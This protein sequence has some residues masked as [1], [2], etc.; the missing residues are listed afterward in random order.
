MEEIS[1]LNVQLIVHRQGQFTISIS[2]AQMV[3]RVLRVV[4]HIDYNAKTLVSIN[5]VS[6]LDFLRLIIQMSPF[7]VEPLLKQAF[8]QQ[9]GIFVLCNF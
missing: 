4:Y 9:Y 8:L 1:Q 6:A 7:R 3:R 2:D 5:C